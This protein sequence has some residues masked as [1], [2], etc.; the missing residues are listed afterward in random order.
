MKSN[1]SIIS[2][3]SYGFNKHSKYQCTD[4]RAAEKSRMFQF[5]KFLYKYEN[6]LIIFLLFHWNFITND[7]DHF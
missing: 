2:K 1:E 7:P 4:I 6:M 5:H 3:P